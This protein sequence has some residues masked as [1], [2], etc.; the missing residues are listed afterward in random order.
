MLNTQQIC[1]ANKLFILKCG[2]VR[3]IAGQCIVFDMSLQKSV[4]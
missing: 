1:T 3:V 2:P 4:C